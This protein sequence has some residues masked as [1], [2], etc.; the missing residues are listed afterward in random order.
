MDPRLNDSERAVRDAARAAAAKA[1]PPP[2][3]TAIDESLQPPGDVLAGLAGPHGLGRCVAADH[4][5][6]DGG[7]LELALVIEEIGRASAS[8]ASVAT[9]HMVAGLVI[10][11]AADDDL[12]AS[13]LRGLA[14]GR[15]LA[16][17]GLDGAGSILDDPDAGATLEAGGDAGRLAGRIGAVAG[18][19][20]ADVFLVPARAAEGGPVAAWAVVERG[21]E[22]VAVG[23]EVAKLGLNGSG[24]AAIA[25]HDIGLAPA[26]I[27]ATGD[28]AA[29]IFAQALDWS[30]IAY[31][32][33]CV[34][35]AAAALDAAT[36]RVLE[37]G[38][39]LADSQ[40]IQWMLADSAT[41]TEAAR[42]LTWYAASRDKPGA[43]REAAA[44]ARLMAADAAVRSSR[45]AV[46]I[47]GAEGSAR[48]AG[49]ERLYRDAK[50][51]EVHHG[52]SEAQRLAVA[53]E[54]LPD[55]VDSPA[56]P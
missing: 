24:L 47:F 54:I 35:I 15:T 51:L 30:R 42:L 53:R 50:A 26:A 1:L 14:E 52:S 7:I 43:L 17:L 13:R 20:L 11:A 41:E 18:A 32:A 49:I 2:L 5:G 4:G 8:L 45:R 27:L 44:M 19:T 21:Q 55:L 34:G 29:A 40:S 3:A 6:G 12:A 56:G 38:G 33:A 37:A 16:A 25:L 31:A 36:R 39:E 46:Q 22:G 9:G 28:R 10:A 23:R 48:E